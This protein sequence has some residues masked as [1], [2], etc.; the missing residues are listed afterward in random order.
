MKIAVVG[1][2][3]SDIGKRDYVNSS[4]IPGPMYS[5]IKKVIESKK[6]TQIDVI[7]YTRNDLGRIRK[8][9]KSKK[10]MTINSKIKKKGI[11]DLTEAAKTLGEEAK[12]N[13]CDVAILFHDADGTNRTPSCA[14]D[15]I[16]ES[17]MNGFSL[18]EFSKGVPMIP[19]PIGEVWFLCAAKG[20]KSCESLESLNGNDKSGSCPKKLLS[21][22]TS[23]LDNFAQQVDIHKINMPSFMRFK[24]RLIEVTS[25]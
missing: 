21:A 13:D 3:N 1:E 14:L 17:V 4:F 6:D 8:D 25:N 23:D 19:K 7:F 22:Y 15:K 12:N 5:I 10:S 20:Y 2:G 16:I 9:K 24:E 11:I 18:A